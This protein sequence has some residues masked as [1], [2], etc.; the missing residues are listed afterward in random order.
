MTPLI[1]GALFYFYAEREQ[2]WT[3]IMALYF[4]A[5]TI[6]TVGY[7]DLAPVTSSNLKPSQAKPSNDGDLEP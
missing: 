7:G 3:Y 4:S 2:Q 1:S 5:V 6:S